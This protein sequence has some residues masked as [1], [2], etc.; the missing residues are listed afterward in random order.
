MRGVSDIEAIRS[1]RRGR[2]EEMN[3]KN[4][5]QRAK[6]VMILYLLPYWEEGGNCG[7]IFQ[8]V[9]VV[10]TDCGLDLIRQNSELTKYK[11]TN[12]KTRHLRLIHYSFRTHNTFLCVQF[13]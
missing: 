11:K 4:F 9:A 5:I 2:N 13:R 8:I 12:G 6:A 7:G 10:A 3:D 1:R